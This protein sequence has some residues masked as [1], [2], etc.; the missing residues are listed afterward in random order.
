MG[1][2]SGKSKKYMCVS[3][4]V[5]GAWVGMRETHRTPRDRLKLSPF[6]L[7]KIIHRITL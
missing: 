2:I 4:I 6:P 3:Y 5:G 7:S 1:S